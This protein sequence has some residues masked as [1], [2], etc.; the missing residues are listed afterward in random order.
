MPKYIGFGEIKKKCVFVSTSYSL[1]SHIPFLI[2]FFFLFNKKMEDEENNI[3]LIKLLTYFG[4]SLYF[5]PELIIKKSMV[6]NKDISSNNLETN[7]SRS[8]SL[9]VEY[10]FKDENEY[11]EGINY[12][13]L[14]YIILISLLILIIDII[15]III[16]VIDKAYPIK[17]IFNDEY[18]LIIFILLFIYY[19][20][21]YKT[22]FYRHQ[23]CPF[24][25]ITIIGIFRYIIKV[26]EIY[27]KQNKYNFGKIIVNLL[28][29]I[30]IA[31]GESFSVLYAKGLM[32]YKYFSPYKACY[33]FGFLDTF[34]LL[35][36]LFII[37]SIKC[38]HSLA[39]C[40]LPY[41]NSYY[42][43]NIYYMF[44]K[45]NWYQF[46]L[47]FICAIF[48][49]SLKV[50]IN[51]SINKFSI[52]HL[53]LLYQIQQFILGVLSGI[54]NM[55]KGSVG[56]WTILVSYI[57]EIF[58]ILVFLEIV[59]LKF[60]DLN[61]M[62]KKNIERRSIDEIKSLGADNKEIF[63]ENDNQDENSNEDEGEGEGITNLIK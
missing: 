61:K 21:T 59:E 10:I 37:S 58:F 48:F 52:F 62:L 20:F 57:P 2:I 38:N 33:I 53:Y 47:L 50:L 32:K 27:I 40:G 24:V 56:S 35:I 4:Q 60:C 15:K 18:N 23:Y 9:S 1:I 49:G 54:T 42:I 26:Y 30:L 25:F 8:K 31:A 51:Y 44:E 43:D 45:Y 13:D 46:I 5:I 6:K 16:Y 22:K 28:A 12:L 19:I 17:N 34:M 3:S 14:F 7:M 11:S 39:I 29:Q 63:Q 36:I 55:S 41:K